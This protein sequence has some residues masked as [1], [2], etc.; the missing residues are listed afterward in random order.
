MFVVKEYPRR[1]QVTM[2][3]GKKKDEKAYHSDEI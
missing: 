2:V 1:R 3:A